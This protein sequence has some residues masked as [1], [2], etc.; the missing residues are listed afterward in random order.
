MAGLDTGKRWGVSIEV[1]LC[2]WCTRTI[3]FKSK[4]SILKGR[5]TSPMKEQKHKILIQV[6]PCLSLMQDQKYNQHNILQTTD[7]ILLWSGEVTLISQFNC[8]FNGVIVF[9]S[10]E[11][12]PWKRRSCTATASS[13]RW[14]WRSWRAGRGTRRRQGEQQAALK[15]E[16]SLLFTRHTLITPRDKGLNLWEEGKGPSWSNIILCCYLVSGTLTCLAVKWKPPSLRNSWSW[17]GGRST[18]PMPA[19]PRFLDSEGRSI[20]EGELGW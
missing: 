5:V 11:H 17:Q 1:I 3:D 19:G 13:R 18:W 2:F 6:A 7:S 20:S 15:K 8:C 4:S 14:T 9:N 10:V 12:P 16:K